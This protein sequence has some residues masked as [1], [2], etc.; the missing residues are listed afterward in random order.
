MPDYHRALR[1]VE[2][3]VTVL[4]ACRQPNTRRT[5][6]IN[7]DPFSVLLRA[8]FHKKQTC[9]VATT[10]YIN[11]GKRRHRRQPNEYGVPPNTIKTSVRHGTGDQQTR[12]AVRLPAI[13]KS[14]PMYRTTERYMPCATR[15]SPTET[16]AVVATITKECDSD[17][18]SQPH[19]PECGKHTYAKAD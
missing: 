14:R 12:A 16:S 8:T 18:W 7:N 17:V 5:G 19:E 3:H 11:K 6:A 10:A 1:P 15:S 4:Q 9:K 13:N 2:I